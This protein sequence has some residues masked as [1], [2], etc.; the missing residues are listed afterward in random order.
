M[1][2]LTMFFAVS[3]VA[4]SDSDNG[5]SSTVA[6]G[7]D[8]PNSGLLVYDT[9]LLRSCGYEENRTRDESAN[10]LIDKG[11]DVIASYCARLS[12]VAFQESCFSPTGEIYVHELHEAN[13]A[14]AEA[15][16]YAAVKSLSGFETSEGF[17][18][19]AL[20]TYER[21]DCSSLQLG[22]L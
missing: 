12:G 22:F 17:V 8:D 4:C 6:V 1:K 18:E 11:I 13:Q 10:I 16:G 2:Y 5:M 15:L 21:S 7:S 20:V 9:Q 3:L 19:Q 14:D